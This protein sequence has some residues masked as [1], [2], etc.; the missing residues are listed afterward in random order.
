VHG[1]LGVLMPGDVVVALSASGETEEILRLL[2]TLKR[3]AMPWSAFVQFE[4]D[5]WPRP[6][7]WPWIA[8][9]SARPAA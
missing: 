2:A 3:K 8:P 6:A 4:L 7:T 5:R 9:W 1:D